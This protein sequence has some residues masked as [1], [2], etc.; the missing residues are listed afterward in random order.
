MI[1]RSHVSECAFGDR[2][3]DV[4]LVGEHCLALRFLL[5]VARVSNTL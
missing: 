2:D 1:T 3:I 5:D 4:F